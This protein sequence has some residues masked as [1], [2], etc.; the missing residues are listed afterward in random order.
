MHVTGLTRSTAGGGGGFPAGAER[1]LKPSTC[2]GAKGFPITWYA[3]LIGA[4]VKKHVACPA[5]GRHV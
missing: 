5:S 4:N 2:K 3:F 1:N